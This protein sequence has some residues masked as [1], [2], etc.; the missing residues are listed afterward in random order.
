[1]RKK[2]FTLLTIFLVVFAVLV[3]CG[4]QEK[5]TILEASEAYIKEL[6]TVFP[7]DTFITLCS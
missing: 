6:Q 1:M 2:A 3:G 4:S 5:K 7:E